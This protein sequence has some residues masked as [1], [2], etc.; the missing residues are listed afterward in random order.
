MNILIS[1]MSLKTHHITS[2]STGFPS[3]I[4]VP[5]QNF[6]NFEPIYVIQKFHVHVDS[7]SP[8][9]SDTLTCVT[10][11]QTYTLNVPGPVCCVTVFQKRLMTGP[12]GVKRCLIGGSFLFDYSS[13][14][15]YSWVFLT[16]F[17]ITP[18]SD[19]FLTSH[20]TTNCIF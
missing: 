15:L 5:A 13:N 14:L 8:Y 1:H 17:F 11:S 2:H 3:H 4:G 19:L 20:V 16:F 7:K 6:S 9:Y 12:C 18:N 10:F